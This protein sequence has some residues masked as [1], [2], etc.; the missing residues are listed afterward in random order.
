MKEIPVIAIDGTTG[1]GKGSIG[2]RLAAKL[3]WHFLD[4]GAIYR[5]LA[6]AALRKNIDAGDHKAL[7]SLAHDLEVRFEAISGQAQ[8]IIYAGSDITVLIRQEECGVFASKIAVLPEVRSALLQRQRRFK[9]PPGL[10]ADGRDMGTV[11]FPEA[12][13]KLFVDADAKERA[14]RRQKQ[15]Q[16]YGINGSFNQILQDL[17]KR[18]QRDEKRAV[19]P[20]KPAEDAVVV[21][22][23]NIGLDEVFAEVWRLVEARGVAVGDHKKT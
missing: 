21:D 17:I 18:D 20:L 7:H 1:S 3:R 11:V 19:A 10:V 6:V 9:R 23:T 22:T 8:R 12:I 16:T 15:L 4:S 14:S 5:I 2:A 13:L